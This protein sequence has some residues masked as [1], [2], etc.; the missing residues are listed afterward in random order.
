MIRPAVANAVILVATAVWLTNFVLDVT[1]P[2]YQPNDSINGVFALL[3]GG[4]IALRDKS[5]KDGDQ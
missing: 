1:V 2:S 5:G 4:V 3:I